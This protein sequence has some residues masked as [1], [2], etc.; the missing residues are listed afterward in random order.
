MCG[1]SSTLLFLS[2]NRHVRMKP[3][4]HKVGVRALSTAVMTVYSITSIWRSISL[5]RTG[6]DRRG[7]SLPNTSTVNAIGFFSSLSSPAAPVT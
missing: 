1:R 7:T 2:P 6:L 5:V 3:V 4:K